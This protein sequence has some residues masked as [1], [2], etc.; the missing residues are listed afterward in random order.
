MPLGANQLSFVLDANYTG[1]F[2]AQLTNAP[3]TRIPH[4]CIANARVS[5]AML[6][7]RLNV[8]VAANNVFDN[9]KP[10]YAFDVSSPPLGGAYNT[11]VKPRWISASV[12]YSF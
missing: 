2:Y 12:K 5:L 7:E 1:D 11:Y 8:S 3:V 9:A 6:N 10:A 4:G